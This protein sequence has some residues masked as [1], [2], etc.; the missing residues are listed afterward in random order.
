MLGFHTKDM[1]QVFASNLALLQVVFNLATMVLLGASLSALTPV[2]M[3]VV[4]AMFTVV[5][6]LVFRFA[7]CALRI[8]GARLH[9]NY[10]S[11][12]QVAQEYLLAILD[13]LLERSQSFFLEACGSLNRP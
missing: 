5:Y 4:I 7:R 6:L 8:D 10:Q 1:D 2:V 12:S 3:D 13:V 11:S 9:I